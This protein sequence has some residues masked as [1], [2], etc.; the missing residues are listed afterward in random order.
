LADANFRFAAPVCGHHYAIASGKI[1]DRVG[2]REAAG[3]MGKRE[4]YFA[5]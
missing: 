1:S 2:R 3:N 5:V 4:Q